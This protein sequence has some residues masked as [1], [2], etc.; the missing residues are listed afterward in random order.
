MAM[1]FAS[2]KFRPYILGFHVII[3]TDHDAI[4]YMMAKKDAKLRLIKWVLLL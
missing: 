1:V 4:K 3:H 2:E